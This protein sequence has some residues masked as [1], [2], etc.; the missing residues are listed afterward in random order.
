MCDFNREGILLKNAP[1]MI[2]KVSDSKGSR[3]RSAI[4]N[5]HNYKETVNSTDVNINIEVNRRVI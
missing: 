4:H 1:Q 5:T 2:A 3:R